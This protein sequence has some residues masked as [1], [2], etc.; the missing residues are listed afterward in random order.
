MSNSIKLTIDGVEV[1]AVQGMTIL[2][3]ARANGIEIPTLCHDE[4]VEAYGA[5]GICVVEA[6]GIPKLLRACAT[7]AND[8]MVITTDSPRVLRSRKF[9]LEMLL[10]DHVGDCKAPCSLACPAGTDCQG[11]VGLIANG[12]YEQAA[13]LIK[14]KIPLPSSIGRICPH[15]CEAKCRRALVDEPV[16]IA[17]LKAFAGD[18]CLKYDDT[19]EKPECET[20]RKIAVVG[21][22]P[23][24]LTAAYYLR[25]MGH[26]VKIYD[27]MPKLGGMLRYGIP[28]YRLPKEILDRE[29]DRILSLGIEVEY[30]KLLGR[31]FT[32]EGLKSENDA[33]VLAVG[34]WKSSRMR[35]AGEELDGVLGGI[36]FLREVVCGNAPEIGE[37][38][39]VCGGGNTAMDACRTA[40]RLGAKEVYIIYRRTRD[41]M[42]AEKIEIDEAEE[43]GVIF[44]FLTNPAEILGENGKVSGIKLQ[45]MR[46]GEPDASGRRSPVPVEGEFETI[47]L[48]TVIMAIGQQTDT[49]GLDAVELTR[50]NTISADEATFATSM[51]GVFAV[52]DATNKGASIAVEAIGEAQKAAEVINSYLDGNIIG[53]K[54]PFV[55]EKEVT[56]ADFADREKLPRAVMSGL[57]PEDRRCNFKEITFGYTEEQALAEGARCLECGC[58]DYFKCRLLRYSREYN[59]DPTPYL[60]E[61]SVHGK[62]FSHPYLLHDNDKCVLCGLCVRVCSE[63]MGVTAIGLAGRGFPTVVTPE[64]FNSLDNSRCISCGQ[65]AALCPTGALEEKVP[66]RKSVPLDTKVKTAV[67]R[68]CA[69]G[70]EMKVHSVGKTVVRCEPAGEKAILCEK[71]RF[72]FVKINNMQRLTQPLVNGKSATPE[73]A[74]AQIKA[75]CGKYAGSTAFVIG[76]GLTEAEIKSAVDFAREAVGADRIFAAD[77]SDSTPELVEIFGEKRALGANSGV[78]KALGIPYLSSGSLDGIKAVAAFGGYVPERAEGFEFIAAESY[79]AIDADVVLPRTFE[80]TAD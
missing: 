64:F 40:V 22:G 48:D 4:R 73:E 49:A 11:Y 66:L 30:G 8:G 6:A 9:A 42:P 72:G 59:A 50:R 26:S 5:C 80:F 16:A 1:N 24:G 20:G 45:I 21:G 77:S 34:A 18:I 51:D 10:S 36:D 75:A 27:K 47:A 46:L 71:G 56:A 44:K 78:I 76:D 12:E 65:C 7:K 60:G 38:V 55:V 17:S 25:R 19:P 2:Q 53:Y 67:C 28:Q 35:V 37:R 14:E 57:S 58:L 39:A 3:A 79:E 54:K 61:K 43:E 41:E 70:C 69:V 31:D 74:Y 52:G 15:P 29:I 33:V 32:V 63:V 13:R 23:G 68:G 62:D